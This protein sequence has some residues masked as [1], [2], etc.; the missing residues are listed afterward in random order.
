VERYQRVGE[1]VAKLMYV[2]RGCC[3]TAGGSAMDELFGE[4]IEQGMD[5]RLDSCDVFFFISFNIV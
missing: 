3:R 5:V 2:D 4:R 1:A